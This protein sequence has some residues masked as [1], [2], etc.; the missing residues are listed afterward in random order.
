MDVR[1][2]H[3][4]VVMLH[5][6]APNRS[7]GALV[8]HGAAVSCCALS[9]LHRLLPTYKSQMLPTDKCFSTA[10]GKSFTPVSIITLHFTIGSLNLKEKF[11][12]FSQ[13]NRSLIF[14]RTFLHNSHAVLDFTRHML[15]LDTSYKLHAIE[16]ILMAQAC[17]Q[18]PRTQDIAQRSGFRSSND[19]ARPADLTS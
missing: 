14:G 12:I 2:Y 4:S 5:F 8:D 7:V 10:D 13:L 11:Y 16:H 17:S 19:T 18:T 15:T 3:D 9:L 6:R 1:L